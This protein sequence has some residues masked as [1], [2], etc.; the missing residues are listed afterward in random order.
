M[1]RIERLIERHLDALEEQEEPKLVAVCPWC[2]EEQ[3]EG[4]MAVLDVLGNMFCTLDCF[5]KHY[6]IREITS[7]GETPSGACQ[8]CG[9]D[10]DSENFEVYTSKQGGYFCSEGCA[11]ESIGYQTILLGGI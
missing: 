7:G 6:D 8:R 1:T 5:S 4:Y 2:N 3:F 11:M 9:I 10:L